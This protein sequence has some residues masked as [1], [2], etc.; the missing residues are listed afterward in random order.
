VD[1]ARHRAWV[2]EA[3]ERADE[4][5]ERLVGAVAR[6]ERIEARMRSAAGR[7]GNDS[8]LLRNSASTMFA[9]AFRDTLG[10]EFGN[11]VNDTLAQ[12]LGQQ[13]TGR[14]ELSATLRE[15]VADARQADLE[16]AHLGVDLARAV[17]R[18]GRTNAR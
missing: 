15:A 9:G 18:E 4:I 11:K 16:V 12:L 2:D 10:T 14:G 17:Q 6:T 3:N 5:L 1:E 7:G 8:A 13:A